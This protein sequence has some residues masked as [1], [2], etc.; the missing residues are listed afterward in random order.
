MSFTISVYAPNV[1]LL[2]P[3]KYDEVELAKFQ[4]FPER[5]WHNTR[6]GVRGWSVPVTDPNIEYLESNFVKG[7]DYTVTN[8]AK[9]LLNY[10]KLTVQVDEMKAQKRWEYLFEDKPPS[11]EYPHVLKPFDHQRVTVEAAYGSEYFGLLME[12]G[13]G[14][15]KCFIDE[16]MIYGLNLKEGEILKIVVSCP[17]SLI[18]NWEREFHK[19]FPDLLNYKIECFNKGELKAIGQLTSLLQDSS[20]IK[21]IIISHDSVATNLKYLKLFKPTIFGIDE[22]HYLKNPSTQRWKAAKGLSEDSAMRRILTG[23]PISNNIMDVWAQFEILSPGILGYSTYTAFKAAFAEVESWSGHDN[24]VGYQEDKMPILKENM[25]KCSFIVKKS[26]CL[27]LPEKMYDTVSVD[28]PE[29]M[30]S[31]YD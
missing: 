10:K 20:N 6:D 23:T 29:T 1:L 14:K 28:M 16:C 3:D 13:T 8:Q 5:K 12:M 31:I 2:I 22:S 21:I 17:K 25:A 19:N 15:T 9:L 18:Y 4:K 7:Q 30:R 26:Q 11:F 24:V 27:D